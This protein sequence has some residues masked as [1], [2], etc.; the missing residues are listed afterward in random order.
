MRPDKDNTMTLYPVI[1]SG[2]CGSRLWPLSREHYPKPLLPLTS[3]QSLLQEAATRL[4]GLP[5]LG[6]AGYGYIQRG[7]EL[8]AG[9]A[10]RVSSFVEKPGLAT[11]ELYLASRETDWNSGIFLMRAGRWLDEIGTQQPAILAACKAA[12]L[13]RQQDSDYFHVQ[14]EAFLASPADCIDYA[15]MEH[16]DSTVVVPFTAGLS[17]V[18]A[19]SSLWQVG[20]RDAKGNVIRG[21]VIAEDTENSLLVAR[22]DKAQ[23][24]RVIV[25]QLKASDLN[26]YK[27]HRCVYRPWVSYGCIDNGPRFQVKRLPVKPGATLSLQMH[28]HRAE[29]WVVAKCSAR[30]TCGDQT[31]SPHENRP[32]SPWAKPTASKTLATSRSRLSRSSLAATLVKTTSSV[33]KSSMTASSLHPEA[34]ETVRLC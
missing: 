21:D 20:P 19:W 11:A 18:G 27:V 4:E 12:M 7:E 1:L 13:Q 22:K 5:G 2:G 16:T 10:Y 23:E 3:G 30:I 26:E 9:Q 8:T 29:H 15:V 28:H 24:V 32:A 34:P 33:S 17:D 6:D 14:R 25:N 31:F